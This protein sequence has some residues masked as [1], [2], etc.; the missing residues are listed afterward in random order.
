[1]SLAWR[2]RRPKRMISNTRCVIS[3]ISNDLEKLPTC[4][5]ISWQIQKQVCFNKRLWW[6]MQK[7]H[8]FISKTRE[9]A[10]KW[11]NGPSISEKGQTNV[12]SLKVIEFVNKNQHQWSL[13]TYLVLEAILCIGR[14]TAPHWKTTSM[15]RIQNRWDDIQPSNWRLLSLMFGIAASTPINFA[16]G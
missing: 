5:F 10:A 13:M 11:S 2:Y 16:L 3:T 14:V 12:W 4:L 8:V 15:D 6:H 9:I 7:S 1:M